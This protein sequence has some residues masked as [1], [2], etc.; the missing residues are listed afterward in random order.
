MADRLLTLSVRMTRRSSI[1]PADRDDVRCRVC[2]QLAPLT[3]EHVPPRSIGNDRRAEWLGLEQ[4]LAR[5]LETGHSTERGRI[6]QRGAGAQSFCATCNNNAGV[7][8]VPEFNEWHKR[9][10]GALSS[11]VPVPMN[12][13]ASVARPARQ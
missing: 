5:D 10:M 9:A 12:S 4:W 1:P 6:Q 8:Y 13:T 7:R 2:G 11:M 3:F